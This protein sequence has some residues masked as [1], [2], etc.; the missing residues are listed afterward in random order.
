MPTKSQAASWLRSTLE[1]PFP[2]LVAHFAATIFEGETAADDAEMGAGGLLGLLAV[3]GGFLS[4]M[5]F[6]KYSSLLQW[7]RGVRHFNIYTE[8]LP[9]KYFF[10]VFSMA[11]TGAVAVLKWDRILPGRRDYANLAPLPI[12]ARRI[13]AANLLAILIIAGVFAVDVNAASVVLYPFVVVANRGTVGELVRFDAV[14]ACCVMLASLFTFLACFSIMSALMALLPY[15]LFRRVSLY[16]RVVIVIALVTLFATSY[17]VPALVQHLPANPE[18]ALLPPVWYLALYQSLQGHAT[19]ELARLSPFAMRAVLIALASAL[20]LSALSYRRC[21][22]RISESSGGP[23]M[24]RRAILRLPA[25]FA[26]L[27][28]HFQRACSGFAIRALVRSEKHCI[29]LGGF[30]GMG[31]VAASETALSAF[32]QPKPTIPDA[33]LLSIALILAYFTICGLRFVFEMPVELDANWVFQVILDPDRHESAAAARNVILT[34]IVA[35]IVVPSLAVYW[36]LWDWRVAVLHAAYLLALSLLL[37]EGLLVG[38]RKIPFTCSFPPFRNHVVMLVVL[39]VIGYSFF[40]GTGSEIEHWMMLHPLR[41]LWLI[42]AAAAA[43]DVLRRFRNEIAPVDAS[44]IYRDQ[45]K[46]TVTTLDLSGN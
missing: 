12:S 44:L 3:P 46:A 27:K 8:S 40:T 26:L 36:M 28:S 9:D 38:F 34:V 35:A 13:F 29:V 22:M 4:L 33:D 15:R 39:G 43:C 5:L 32:A 10:I 6:D 45:A 11:I 37:T 16:V 7:L 41:F 23:L 25:V 24:R 20:L 18:V 21:F 17:A 42:P 2:R 14:H 31:L 30:A 1:R 19:P